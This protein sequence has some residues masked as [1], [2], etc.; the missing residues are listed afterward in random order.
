M[1]KELIIFLLSL[2]IWAFLAIKIAKDIQHKNWKN[3]MSKGTL[4]AVV[5]FAM[6]W[7]Y[8]S[9]YWTS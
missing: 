9:R 4:I 1:K 2:P 3:A 5:F 7:I 6:V 8:I